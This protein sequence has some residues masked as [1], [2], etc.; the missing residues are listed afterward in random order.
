MFDRKGHWRHNYS[1]G[2]YKGYPMMSVE[3]D[4]NALPPTTLNKLDIFMLNVC[5][6]K[7]NLQKLL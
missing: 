4:G 3:I 7:S 6:L 1:M 5:D 2:T